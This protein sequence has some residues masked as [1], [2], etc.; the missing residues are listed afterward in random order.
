MDTSSSDVARLLR[1]LAVRALTLALLVGI[2]GETLPTVLFALTGICLLLVPV[3]SAAD[4]RPDQ[5]AAVE[6]THGPQSTNS[7]TSA[8]TGSKRT[9][10]LLIPVRRLE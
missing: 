5:N 3:E 10:R 6:S 1:L 2:T 4:R 9:G 7:S 8:E